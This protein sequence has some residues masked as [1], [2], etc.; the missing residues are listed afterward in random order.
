MAGMES[1]AQYQYVP[2][3]HFQALRLS[4]VMVIPLLT[5]AGRLRGGDSL[6]NAMTCDGAMPPLVVPAPRIGWHLSFW[7]PP[8]SRW[9]NATPSPPN[10]SSPMIALRV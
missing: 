2:S 8:G 5:K 7:A 10:G 9:R 1:A 3:S 6:P 4:A